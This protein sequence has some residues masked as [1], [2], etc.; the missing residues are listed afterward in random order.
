MMPLLHELHGELAPHG[1]EI[2]GVNSDGGQTTAAEVQE[3]LRGHPAPYPIVLD[4]G[5]ANAAYK[6]RALPQMVLVGRDG[7]VRQ[8]FI[9][10][11]SRGTLA[12]AMTR[13]LD[14]GPAP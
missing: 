10:Y 12:A 6:V 8:V 7:A 3:F 11:T 4:D 14:E 13:A 9:G 1:L 5:S 2:V